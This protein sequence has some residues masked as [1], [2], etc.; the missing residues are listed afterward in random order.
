MA[1]VVWVLAG[2][3]VVVVIGLVLGASAM[4][5]RRGYSVGGSTIV[6]C[7]AGH[8]FTTIW[9]PLASFKA[10]RLGRT[11]FQRCPVGQHW[12][13]VTPLRGEELT[14]VERQLAAQF[15]DGPIP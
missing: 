10:I 6:R 14:D 5:R 12:A 11:R 1:G 3:P 2:L 15:H 9:V 7:S 8:L 13:L 4:D